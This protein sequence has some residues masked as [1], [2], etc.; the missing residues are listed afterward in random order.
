MKKKLLTILVVVILVLSV[1]SLCFVGCNKSS[2]GG[3]G[4]PADNPNPNPNPD[5]QPSGDSTV[6]TEQLRYLESYANAWAV[7]NAGEEAPEASKLQA[8][9]DGVR[10]A[11]TNV[12]KV[13]V[14]LAN[15]K[16]TIKV[17]F[18]DNTSENVT[19]N[20]KILD[21]N[22]YQAGTA[23][24]AGNTKIE[25]IDNIFVPVYNAAM[26]TIKT[27]VENGIEFAE[28]EQGNKIFSASAE[29]RAELFVGHFGEAFKGMDAPFDYA[30]SISGNIGRLA[31]DT[32]IAIEVKQ[33]QNNKSQKPIVGLYY[34]GAEQKADCKIYLG[35]DVNGYTQKL[36]IDNADLNAL[37]INMMESFSNEIGEDVQEDATAGDEEKPFW[38]KQVSSLSDL[39]AD[40][41]ISDTISTMVLG[42]VDSVLEGHMGYKTVN[43]ATRYQIE[44]DLD[45]LLD[46]VLEV[47][48]V[49][50]IVGNLVKEVDLLKDLDPASMQGIGGKLV[51][52]VSVKDG[53][54]SGVA[55]N[56]NVDESDFRFNESDT[57]S[58]AYGPINFGLSVNNFSLGKQN[59]QIGVGSQREYTYFSPLNLEAQANF[60]LVETGATQRDETY[61][62]SFVSAINPFDMENGAL[63]LTV[64]DHQGNIV[65]NAYGEP[66]WADEGGL[67]IAMEAFYNN[68]KT[69][70][71]YKFNISETGMPLWEYIEEAVMS[72]D[73]VCA[74]VVE[75]IQDL[76]EQFGFGAKPAEG[77]VAQAE[78]EEEES[79]F[80]AMGLV[81]II[82]GIKDLLAEL[83]E[84]KFIDYPENIDFEHLENFYFKA[85]LNKDAYNK[86]LVLLREAW[87]DLKDFD[88]NAALV[89][90]YVNYGEQ[91]KGR[92]YVHVEY[93]DWKVDVD[94][95]IKDWDTNKKAYAKVQVQQGNDVTVYNA[96]LDASGWDNLNT[97]ARLTYTVK[98][99]NAAADKYVDVTIKQLKATDNDGFDVH[100]VLTTIVKGQQPK[101]H[102]FDIIVK[103]ENEGY[104][105]QGTANGHT[106]KVYAGKGHFNADSE[107]PLSW[108]IPAPECGF[109]ISYD[110]DGNK[111]DWT[112]NSAKITNWGKA[113]A[114]PTNVKPAGQ[115]AL[116]GKEAVEGMLDE[117][118]AAL[119]PYIRIAKKA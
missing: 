105:F 95:S 47:E 74:P 98:K 13:Q 4:T 60:T 106:V 115:D 46:K 43:G 86:V 79:S 25:S 6:N 28:D 10:A 40:L 24:D 62:L 5:P 91:Y 107:H 39:L 36:Y 41:G 117:L 11:W 52:S 66:F 7:N 31:K 19:V 68:G 111:A 70:N 18:K 80:N 65:L 14:K 84:G 21:A 42:I 17:T 53:I 119:A 78:D 61:S 94:L 77:Q 34:M 58:K 69:S 85:E 50:E 22:R 44:I 103:Q 102:I 57:E 114:K 81:N 33:G 101:N 108:G 51:L 55:L 15:N 48:M 71:S 87:P 54:L 16:Y 12:K 109:E 97:G 38:E 100:A 72:P 59:V 113:V 75:Y 63:Q 35:I 90:V 8:A 56:Y 82:T 64:K 110:L 92:I 3:S 9:I 93:Q 49:S 45:D 118:D 104:S 37:V 96:E 88:N 99:G 2:G 83:K 27:A 32:Q 89:D 29:L 67:D 1:M 73:S 26:K 112:I 20:A 116:Q 30:L 76:M 23:Y